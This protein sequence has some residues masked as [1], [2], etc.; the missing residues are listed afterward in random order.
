MAMFF[1]K[2]NFCL[3]HAFVFCFR[4][5]TTIRKKMSGT[6]IKLLLNPPNRWIKTCKNTL[7]L[8]TTFYCNCKI[9]KTKYIYKLTLQNNNN[10]LLLTRKYIN[11]TRRKDKKNTT[12]INQ[13]PCLELSKSPPPPP[14]IQITKCGAVWIR[15]MQKGYSSQQDRD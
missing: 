4:Q 14:L 5:R 8:L 7:I 12:P 11:T 2:P 9:L 3:K 6:W 15:K 10:K 13:Q 1:F